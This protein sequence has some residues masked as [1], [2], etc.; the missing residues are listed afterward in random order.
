MK[1][2]DEFRDR[3]AA[4]T[5]SEALQR[6]TTRPWTLMEVCGG[7]THSIVKH[8][9]D[10]LQ[11]ARL[12]NADL[13]YRQMYNALFG[14][15][16]VIPVTPLAASPLGNE[17]QQINWNGL[18]SAQQNEVSRVFANLGKA[19]AAYERKLMPG[20]TRFDGYARSIA[21]GSEFDRGEFLSSNELAG[22]RLFIGK[23]QCVSCHNGPL[24]TNHEFHNT[25]VLSIARQ[26]PSMGRY[27]GIR[28]ARSDP[29]G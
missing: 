7:Q 28:T 1:Y 6:L 29:G 14:P 4:Q 5:I 13:R 18:S 16:P 19:I 27:E 22:L 25:G 20:A 15:L 2:V 3:D 24:F 26:L 17:Q 10:R 11:A 21:A 23:A 8:G 9:I 12:I